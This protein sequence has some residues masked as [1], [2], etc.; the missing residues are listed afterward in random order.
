MTYGCQNEVNPIERLLLKRPETAWI[1]QDHLRQRWQE[2][3]YVGCPNYHAACAEYDEFVEI[4]RRVVPEID[5]LPQHDQTGLDSLYVRDASL[6]TR[7]GAILCNMG[8]KQRRG[9]PAAVGGFYTT[10]G[11]PILGEI[12][13]DGQLEGGDV[14]WLD[15]K[16]LVVGEG[17]RTNAEGIRQLRNLTRELVDE[18]IVVPL[19]HW[20]GPNDVLHLM[21]MIS[22][23]DHDL[24]VI[25]SRM[26]PVPIRNWLISRGIQLIEVPD[27]EFSSMAG[28]ILAVAPRKC[29]MLAGNPRTREKLDHQG[30][31][32]WEF[33]GDEIAK[34]GAGGPTCLTRPLLRGK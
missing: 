19:P 20:D 33:R 6:V 3:N 8:K 12:T 14:V 4:L 22:P 28:N 2:L 9:E 7:A 31:E 32:V 15:E 23:L 21:S 25:Y 24:A 13:G 16:T 27:T 11:I 17:Y 29:L 34:K 1:D 18:F 30:V 26:M 10:Q 5:F